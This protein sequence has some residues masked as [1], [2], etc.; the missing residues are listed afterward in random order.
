MGFYDM[1]GMR[2]TNLAKLDVCRIG[3]GQHDLVAT[4][5]GRVE[6]SHVR[7]RWYFTELVT[8]S[9]ADGVNGRLITTG[10]L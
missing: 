6:Q 9:L 3:A 7:R 1:F 4:S 10:I 8:T 2:L 5:S